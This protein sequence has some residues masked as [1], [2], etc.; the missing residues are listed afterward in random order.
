MPFDQL[1]RR[2]FIMLVGG[3]AAGWPLAA[4]A[5]QPV[6]VIGFLH[7]G[8][9]GERIHLLTGLREGLRARGY[10]EGQNVT[11][12]Y[13]WADDQF[14][15]LPALAAELVRRRSSSRRQ[16]VRSRRLRPKEPRRRYRSSS[17]AK[18]IL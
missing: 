9:L 14:D 6:P 18:T 13:R 2:E 8:S 4:R 5:Q 15:R 11:I 10:L 17:A 3:A 7:S 12:E 16:R 1:K